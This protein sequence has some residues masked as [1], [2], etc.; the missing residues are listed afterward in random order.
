MKKH[1]KNHSTFG[2]VGAKKHMCLDC[3]RLV[4][5]SEYEEEI[6]AIQQIEAEKPR[7]KLTLKPLKD[8]K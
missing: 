7:K 4:D 3:N 8:K 1:N 6:K 5:N 2:G